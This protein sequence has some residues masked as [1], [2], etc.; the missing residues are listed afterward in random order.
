MIETLWFNENL[1]RTLGIALELDKDKKFYKRYWNKISFCKNNK[2]FQ[3]PCKRHIGFSSRPSPK[4][5]D[6]AEIL[7]KLLVFMIE[8]MPNICAFHGNL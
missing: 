3:Q 7:A 4:N 1:K 2:G 8:T 6:P 5:N